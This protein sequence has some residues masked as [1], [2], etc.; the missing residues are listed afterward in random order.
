LLLPSSNRLFIKDTKNRDYHVLPTPVP[1][2]SLAIQCGFHIAHDFNRG[3][4]TIGA[5]KTVSTVY[6][7]ANLMDRGFYL[8]LA[9]D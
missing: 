8:N 9:H 3:Y 1:V 4:E 6:Q 2:S 5:L 7:P